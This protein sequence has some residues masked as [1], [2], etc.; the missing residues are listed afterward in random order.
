MKGR[1]EIRTVL[2]RS[3]A[4]ASDAV[5]V[6]HVTQPRRVCQYVL[7]LG[8]GV[9]LVA[10]GWF[11]EGRLAADDLALVLALAAAGSGA[12]AALLAVF[13]ARFGADHQAGWV[14]MALACYGLLVIPTSTIAAVHP[15]PDTVAVRVLADGI[16]MCLLLIA[17]IAP[18]RLSLQRVFAVLLGTAAAV[19]G[20]A[21]LGTAL[22]ET[23]REVAGVVPIGVG[24]TL[25]W[26]ASGVAIAARAANRQNRGLWLVGV[27]IALLGV[28]RALRLTTLEWPLVDAEEVSTGLR[29]VAV[30]LVLCGALGLARQA[31]AQFDNRHDTLEEELRLAVARLAHTAERDHE[32]RNGLAG[33][34]GAAALVD[35]SYPD[36][37][38]LGTVVAS[39][40]SRLDM[41]LR[42]P[43]GD[44]SAELV[45]PYAVAPV[46]HGLVTLR[47][48]SG[49][50]IR[51]EVEPDLH[52]IGS[53]TTLAQVVT[54][55][56]AN[57]ERH[58]PR[59]P[60]EITALRR[61]D[62]VIVQ[63]RDFGPGLPPGAEDAMFGRGVCDERAG[64][65][66]LGLYLCRR[67][68]AAENGAL[69]PGSPGGEEPGCVFT[70]A[71]RGAANPWCATTP[72][73]PRLRTAS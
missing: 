4:G 70:V 21:A 26:A 40:L 55:L 62:R 7:A 10:T 54:N 36:P 6:D 32:L 47:D 39:E 51:L 35:G 1:L 13:A 69:T 65:L 34:A 42:S 29:L 58:A 71:L 67:L 31:L 48:S 61:D 25:A 22:P 14:S 44:R 11:V 8:A 56:L 28:A 66:G 2:D 18:P 63:V 27:G 52:A 59:S 33:L 12:A 49:M 38:R 50:D 3:A 57:A 64:G 30:T 9:V 72:T 37:Q 17:A 53:S 23:V 73:R 5:S 68:L 16:V 43:V 20:A 46:L 45:T 24:L 19:I 41:L 15:A 60:V